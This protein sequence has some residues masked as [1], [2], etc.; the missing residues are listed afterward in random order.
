MFRSLARALTASSAPRPLVQTHARNGS[1]RTIRKRQNSRKEEVTQA[2][3]LSHSLRKFYLL[4]HPDLMHS[5]PTEKAV[6]EASLQTFNEFLSS[7]K[8]ASA[9]KWPPAQGLRLDFYLKP[10]GLKMIFFFFLVFC[11]FLLWS[12]L[13]IIWLNASLYLVACV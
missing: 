1:Y 12:L 5:H 3:L 2:P 11:F 10:G 13:F 9:D 7:I 8:S 4:T 6:N